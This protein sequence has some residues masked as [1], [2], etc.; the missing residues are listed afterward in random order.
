MATG[1]SEKTSESQ[2]CRPRTGTLTAKAIRK[3]KA[4]QKSGPAGKLPLAMAPAAPQ[5]E[6]ARLRVEPEDRHQ[7]RRGGDEGVEE[8]SDRRLRPAIFGKIAPVHGDEDSHRHQRQLPEAVVEH[9][10]QRD[11]DA[12]HGRLLDQK[13]RVEDLAARLNG[14]PACQNAHW[15]EQAGKHNQPERK[16]VHADVVVDGGF[17]I[18]AKS[19][20]N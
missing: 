14:L 1:A 10:V 4:A 9:Q 18:Q 7:Q 8:E 5:T 12:E 20:T 16:A 6:A 19:C 2:P 11:E 3:A 13:E 17:A 15:R